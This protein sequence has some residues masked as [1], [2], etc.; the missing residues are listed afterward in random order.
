MSFAKIFR[1][2]TTCRQVFGL[3]VIKPTATLNF[4]FVAVLINLFQNTLRNV[5]FVSYFAITVIGDG[6]KTIF[7]K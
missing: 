6:R 1:N 4:N 7:I 5:M 3:V 2:K